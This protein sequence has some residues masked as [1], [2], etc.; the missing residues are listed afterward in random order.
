[1][2]EQAL[3]AANAKLQALV[4]RCRPGEGPDGRRPE[5]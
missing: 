1:M 4:G 2:P 5:T 3:T